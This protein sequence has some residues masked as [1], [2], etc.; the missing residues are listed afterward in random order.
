MDGYNAANYP[1][2]VQSIRPLKG[3]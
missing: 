2:K 1:E 3:T